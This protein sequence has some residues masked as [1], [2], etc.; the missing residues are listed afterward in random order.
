MDNR[1]LL[2]FRPNTRQK[3]LKVGTFDYSLGGSK[4]LLLPE[5]GYLARVFLIFDGALTYSNTT[6]PADLAPYSLFKR[7]SVTLNNSAT[8][9][10]NT[11]GFGAFLINAVKTRMGRLD[12]SAGD[13]PNTNVYA[14]PQS[15]SAQDF[16][17]AVEIPIALSQGQNF[18]AGL[19]NLQAP[20]VQCQ[21]NVDFAGA[22]ADIGSLITELTG[23]C[24]VYY[25][26]YEVPSP[27]AVMQPAVVLHR[28][29]EQTQP[30]NSTGDVIYTVPRGGNMLRLIQTLRLNNARSDSY[31]ETSIRFN[32]SE[33]IY[34]VE[35][36]L[37]KL[38]QRERYGY[39]MPTGVIVHDWMYALN[40]PE[41]SDLRDAI[42]TEMVTTTDA[43]VTVSASAS[44]GSNNNYLTSVRQ[45]LQSAQPV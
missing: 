30:V 38:I 43:I 33:T 44:L 10:Y 1:Q 11:S 26:Y 32:Q 5:I 14:Y 41:E 8:D 13:T 37:Q 3:R 34:K 15:G 40:H 6:T 9:I 20:E 25:E 18:E 24:H 22:L 12:K 31:D 42:N 2:A 23:T 16:N 17:L 45:I 27:Q 36:R 35:K 21:I 39:D 7:I 29:I 4:S 19:I 28:I